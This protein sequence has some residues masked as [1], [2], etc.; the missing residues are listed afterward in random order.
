VIDAEVYMGLLLKQG[1]DA[2]SPQP[3]PRPYVAPGFS[4]D[5]LDP[6]HFP[7]IIWH[8]TGSGQ[9]SNGPGLWL[10]S[11]SV[12]IFGD[13]MDEAKGVMRTFYDLVHSWNDDPAGTVITVDGSPV[14]VSSVD[15]NDLPSR[16][17]SADIPGRNVV[18]YGGVFPLALRG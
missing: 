10:Y 5:E 12:N 14:W 2:I 11:L 13:G 8:L 16:F 9:S 6:G 1:Y 17:P 4:T 7:A 3:V 15:D 18:Q